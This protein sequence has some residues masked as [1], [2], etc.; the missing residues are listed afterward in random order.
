MHSSDYMCVCV[1]ACVCVHINTCRCNNKKK[2]KGHEFGRG[3]AGQK[4][5]YKRRWKVVHYVNMVL[6][7]EILQEKISKVALFL[8]SIMLQINMLI[9]YSK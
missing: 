8:L 6:I 1:S 9:L 7:Y 3:W 5:I 2:R 4:T